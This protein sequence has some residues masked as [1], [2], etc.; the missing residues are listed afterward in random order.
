[1]LELFDIKNCDIIVTSKQLEGEIDLKEPIYDTSYSVE[2]IDE[3]ILQKFQAPKI[4]N[5]L[6]KSCSLKMPEKNEMIVDD[7]RIFELEDTDRT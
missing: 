3:I 2:K 6:T 4:E 7:F 1:M 5:W